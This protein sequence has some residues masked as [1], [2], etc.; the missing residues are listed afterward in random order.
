VKGVD[1]SKIK[2]KYLFI[3]IIFIFIILS[4]IYF[5]L[6]NKELNEA[7]IHHNFLDNNWYENLNYR[8]MGSQLFGLEK[9]STL[10]YEVNDNYSSYLTITTINTITLKSEKEMRNKVEEMV[11]SIVDRGIFIDI[12]SKISG[13]RLLKNGHKTY[14]S[15]FHGVDNSKF[16]S[17]LVYIIIEVWNCG[18]EDNSIICLGFSKVTDKLNNNL[19]VNISNWQKIVGDPFE[20]F[21]KNLFQREDA[22]IYNIICH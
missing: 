22:L 14:Y 4:A 18:I 12:N 11:E 19:N 20:T 16:T 7:Y 10:R 15:I 17:E 6:V 3:S 13:E 1:D 2:I 8:E 9:W 21:G 5:N